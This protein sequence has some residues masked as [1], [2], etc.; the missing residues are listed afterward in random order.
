M[1]SVQRNEQKGE[2]T[3]IHESDRRQGLVIGGRM[4]GASCAACMASS[5]LD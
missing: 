1:I 4:M 2:S 3:A 5:G